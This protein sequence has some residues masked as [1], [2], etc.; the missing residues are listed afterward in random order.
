[1]QTL[2]QLVNSA[3]P[4]LKPNLI[5]LIPSLLE[6]AGELE[7]VGLS[8]L[9]AQYGAQAQTQEVIDVVRANSAKSHYTTQ[10][11]TKVSFEIPSILNFDLVL[12]FFKIKIMLTF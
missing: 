8:Y 12:R 7:S 5:T 11:V 1:M 10:T 6:A 2:S 3:G 4:S 9:S